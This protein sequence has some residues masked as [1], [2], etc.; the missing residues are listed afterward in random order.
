MSA[1]RETT[2]EGG[3]VQCCTGMGG[4]GEGKIFVPSLYKC[5]DSCSLEECRPP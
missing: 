2:I 3:P 5:N 1:E 4:E